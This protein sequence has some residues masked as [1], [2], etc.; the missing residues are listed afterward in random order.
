MLSNDQFLVSFA[1]RKSSDRQ[2]KV[3]YAHCSDKSDDC[4]Y[5][6]GCFHRQRD[7]VIDNDL[8][9]LRFFRYA[10]RSSKQIENA[11]IV[12]KSRSGLLQESTCPIL[13]KKRRNINFDDY[14][15]LSKLD[16]LQ[17]LRSCHYGTIL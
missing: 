12:L 9:L 14:D 6:Y 11:I 2:G 10:D 4:C 5:R 1:A 17:L 15:Y 16:H 7:D 13:I 3:S 8:N